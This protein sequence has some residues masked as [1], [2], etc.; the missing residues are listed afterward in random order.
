MTFSR[1]NI[2]RLSKAVEKRLGNKRF[3]HTLGVAKSAV[4]LA[5]LC[6]SESKCE[7]EIAG[8]LHDIT[9]E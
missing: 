3:L 8:L 9:K 4:K 5:D 1:E 2:E 7:A 6:E